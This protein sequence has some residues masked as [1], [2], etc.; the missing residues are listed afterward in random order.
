MKTTV[1]VNFIDNA[2]NSLKRVHQKIQA[3]NH[4]GIYALKGVLT[5]GWHAVG[6][7]AYLRLLPE[8]AVFDAW[9]QDYLNEGE[10]QLNLSR[11]AHW[12]ERNRLS[13]F[14]IARSLE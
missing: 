13:F 9:I 3:Y 11:D 5:W 2:L 8:R 14:G 4:D 7:L 6:L 12:G 10:P 1:S